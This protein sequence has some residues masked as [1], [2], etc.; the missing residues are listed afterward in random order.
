LPRRKTSFNKFFKKTIKK[1]FDYLDP[2]LEFFGESLG[3]IL[4]IV[5]YSGPVPTTIQ[6]TNV[7]SPILQSVNAK[8]RS[9]A[10]SS[11]YANAWSNKYPSKN[12]SLKRIA[13]LKMQ[14]QNS[15]RA[16]FE[17]AAELKMTQKSSDKNEDS[18]Q[19]SPAMKK[20]L[21]DIELAEWR[22]V[23]GE[24]QLGRKLKHLTEAAK[25]LGFTLKA[26]PKDIEGRKIELLQ[27]AEHLLTRPGLVT[28]LN[29]TFNPLEPAR[30]FGDP[31]SKVIL[32]F[33]NTPFKNLFIIEESLN[34]FFQ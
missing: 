16:S 7:P 6:P 34:L 13:E 18:N 26:S 9:K 1:V 11:G 31:Q 20:L 21:K 29:G 23:Y 30:N 14:Q 32:G 5:A 28:H 19:L 3:S 10:S 8:P 25:A 2:V 27:L 33:D 15:K 17:K 12:D 4:R 22:Y 24:K